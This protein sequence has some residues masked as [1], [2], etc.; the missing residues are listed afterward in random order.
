MPFVICVCV[1]GFFNHVICL[2]IYM[3]LEFDRGNEI[4][5]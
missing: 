2:Y 4:L 5:W 3:V 1:V